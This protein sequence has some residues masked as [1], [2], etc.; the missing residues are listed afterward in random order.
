[1][2]GIKSEILSELLLYEVCF[3]SLNERL[4]IHT[5]VFQYRHGHK[6]N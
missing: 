6:E 2:K 3:I 4:L 1:M 5:R